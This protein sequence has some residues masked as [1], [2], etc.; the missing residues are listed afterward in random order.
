MKPTILWISGWAVPHGQLRRRAFEVLPEFQHEEIC[1]APEALAAASSSGADILGGFSFGAHLLLHADDARPR[2]LLAPFADLKKEAG[3]GGGVATTQLRQQL[4]WLKRDPAAAIADFR[5]RIGAEP[6]DMEERHDLS[7]L[8]W[9]LEQMLAPGRR[10]LGLPE[11]SLAVAGANDPL[12]ESAALARNIPGLH[13]VES[14]HQALPL[15]A[16]IARLRQTGGA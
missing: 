12:L 1:P 3:L 15:L 11:G 2:F 5:R 8:V 6:P 7:L 16:E 9:G 4:R 10:A 13:V 14:G